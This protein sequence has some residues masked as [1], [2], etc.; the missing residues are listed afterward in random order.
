MFPSIFSGSTHPILSNQACR[1]CP[2]HRLPPSLLSQS[3]CVVRRKCARWNVRVCRW[4]VSGS[5]LCLSASQPCPSMSARWPP[6][7]VLAR[8]LP[9]IKR[10]KAN[11]G[12]QPLFA[13]QLPPSRARESGFAPWVRASAEGRQDR[14]SSSLVLFLSF[15]ARASPNTPT[16]AIALQSWA[17]PAPLSFR[18]FSK[19]N[20]HTGCGTDNLPVLPSS[21]RD[22][23]CTSLT[24]SRLG[25]FQSSSDTQPA[26]SLEFTESGKTRRK[27]GDS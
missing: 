15:E 5:V 2:A 8:H 18:D 3:V 4:C 16:P 22:T 24:P 23:D 12:V 11:R 19:A 25:T 21:L 6:G 17:I 14:G 1:A 10:T 7:K 26:P 27:K 13:P 20:S 9:F